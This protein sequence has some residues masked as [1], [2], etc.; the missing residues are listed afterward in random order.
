[1]DKG[2]TFIPNYKLLP[3]SDVY[4]AQHRLIRSLKLRDYFDEADDDD[5]DFTIKSFTNKSTWTPADH[6]LHQSTLDSVQ[7]ILNTTE[8]VIR[9]RKMINGR[10]LLLRNFEDNLTASERTALTELKANADIIIKPADKGSA[11]VVMD[12]SAYIAEAHRQLDNATYYR[13]LDHPSYTDNVKPINDV[14]DEMAASNVISKKQLHFLRANES[15]RQRIFYLLPKI[16]KP[17]S[18]WP[19]P[20]RMPEGRPI[21]SDC[22]S[23]SYRV[24]QYIDSFIRPISIK[25]PSYIKDTYDFVSK[26]RGQQIP[27]EAFLVTGDV[28]SLYTNMRIDRTIETTTQALAR[29]P[30]EGRPDAH[31][32]KLLDITLRNNDFVFD[33]EFYLQICGTAMGKTY[34]PGLAD[35]Y[36]EHFDHVATTGFHIKPLLFF[37][38]LDDT[39]FVWTGTLEQ[40]HEYETFLN[41]I[42]PG[43][44]ITLNV[45][46]TSV[47]FLDTTIYKHHPDFTNPKEAT[48]LTKVYFKDTDTHQLLHKDSFHPRHT[49]KGVLKS[50]IL[51]FQRISSTYG[52]FSAA[53][54]VLFQSLKKRKYSSRLM[55]KMKVEIWRTNQSTSSSSIIVADADADIKKEKL[56]P[57]I[58][59]YNEIGVE[60]AKRWRKTI[61]KTDIFKHHRLI[62]AYRTSCN[63][64]KNLVRSMLI[65]PTR[66]ERLL[67]VQRTS[68]GTFQ[69]VN[70][71]CRVCSYIQPGAF[72]RSHINCH[73]FNTIGSINCKTSNV[74]YLISCKSCNQQYVGETSRPLADRVNTHLSCIRTGKETPVA[75]HFNMTGHSLSD[76]TIAG[77]EHINSNNNGPTIRKIKES[78]WQ[79]LLQT[80]YPLGINNLKRWY[81]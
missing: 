16:H 76:F 77:I 31:I 19:Q 67:T 4:V 45:S 11:T 7:E 46:A 39:F 61:E 9:H 80:A 3:I 10:Q 53:C 59:P 74:I 18:K 58:V 51:R 65:T 54:R 64:R 21:V 38:F 29:H 66:D 68:S 57:V 62:T 41:G 72:V 2:L 12:R 43:I 78:T 70:P 17:R 30:V 25:H 35:I 69:C 81:L 13:K 28:C 22:G 56:L 73:S 71:R 44:T 20:D 36:L 26:V 49:T 52:D 1:L 47:N 55:R 42:I 79:N 24:S 5:Y 60:L 50:Q 37:R 32:I 40:L 23:E 15:D 34:A 14:L 48:L 33:N 63:L 8:S 27:K 75:I 6:K